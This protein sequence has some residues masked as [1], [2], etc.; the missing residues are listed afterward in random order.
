MPRKRLED[1]KYAFFGSRRYNQWPGT[2]VWGRRKASNGVDEHPLT[3]LTLD[4]WIGRRHCAPHC[5]DCVTRRRI[6]RLR[7]AYGRKR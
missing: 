4:N 7:Q 3:A 2:S 1:Q 5:P 6:A